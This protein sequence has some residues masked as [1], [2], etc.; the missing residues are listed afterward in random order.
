MERD[1]LPILLIVTNHQLHD[2]LPVLVL[3]LHKALKCL[4][5]LAELEARRDEPVSGGRVG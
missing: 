3:A 2:E 4:V 5:R 1:A